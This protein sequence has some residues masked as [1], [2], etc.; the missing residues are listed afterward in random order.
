MSE[1]EFVYHCVFFIFSFGIVYPPTEF[2]SIG[3]TIN[4]IF[5]SFLASEEIEFV[6]YHLRRT[7]LTLIV[8]A[9]L[10]L[11]Y[12]SIYY[13]KFAVLLEYDAIDAPLTFIVWNSVVLFGILAPIIATGLVFYWQRNNWDHHPIIGNLRKYC[14]ADKQWERVA[15]DVNAEFRR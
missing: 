14:N 11:L 6:Q 7:C 1:A 2:V 9:F 13:L 5:A 12:I 15:A 10:P 4:H 3:L 8:H